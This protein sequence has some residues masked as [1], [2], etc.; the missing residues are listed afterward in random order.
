MRKR[1]KL[2]KLLLMSL[3]LLAS[4]MAS[5]VDI[6]VD[7]IKYTI[8]LT[9]K[10]ATVARQT[11]SLSKQN[12]VIPDFVTYNGENYPVTTIANRAFSVCSSLTGSLT[13]GNNVTSIGDLAFSKCSGFTGSLTIGNSVTS[14]GAYAFSNCSGFTG[15]LTIGNSVTSIGEYAFSSCSG[16][17]GSLTIPNSVTS[18]GDY[19]FHGCS[20]FTG[21]LTLPNSITSISN[22]TFGLCEGLSGTLTIPTS[23][24][25]IGERA[26][27]S[28]KE[29]SGSLTIPNSVT[30]IG[31]YAF[32]SCSGFTG[33][34][35]IGDSVTSIG[36]YAFAF[37][38]GFAG[39]LTIGNAVAFIGDNAFYYC[40]GFSTLKIGTGV[41][42]IVHFA[43]YF[44]KF[45]EIT[46]E[47][48]IPPTIIF[49][50]DNKY[51]KAFT[52]SN[53]SKPLYV[54][55]E[56]LQDYKTAYEWKDFEYIYPIGW[57]EPTGITLDKEAVS[58]EVKG[59][60]TLAATVA[61][62]DASDKSVTWT[63]SSTSIAT[64]MDGVV[65][66]VKAGTATI[67]ATTVNGLKA[68]CKVTVVVPPSSV[69]IYPTSK[70]LKPSE[71]VTLSATVSPSSAYDKSV[72]WTSSN[73]AVAE[74]DEEGVVTAIS[75]GTATITA[76]TIN[77][78]TATCKVTVSDPD[79][80][81]YT[82]DDTNM[83]ATVTGLANSSATLN[84]PVIPD[85]KVYNGKTYT[86]TAIKDS[87]FANSKKLTGS[88]TIGN[89]VITIGKTAFASC[90]ALTG[91]LTIGNSVSIISNSAFHGCKGFT[92]SLTIP[93]SVTYIGNEA[94]YNCSG[95]TGDLTIGNA[96]ESIGY[97]AF[98]N[99]T[100]FSGSLTIPNSVTTLGYSAFQD[101]TGFTGSLTIGNALTAIEKETFKG[102]DGF[103]GT[104]TIGNS[105]ATIGESAFDGCTQFTGSLTIPNSTIEIGQYAFRNCSA[106]DGTL[107]LGENLL[108][109]GNYAFDHCSGLN[110]RLTIPNSVTTIGERAFWV[111]SGFTGPLSLSTSLSAINMETFASCESIESVIIPA[112]VKTIDGGAFSD[113]KSL[114]SCTLEDSAEAISIPGRVTGYNDF[115]GHYFPIYG[116]NHQFDNCPLTYLYIGRNIT[117][118]TS[119]IF[120]GN[121]LKEL[122]F[123][124]EVTKIKPAFNSHTSIVKVYS[125]NTTPPQVETSNFCSTTTYETA[126]LLVPNE[127]REKYKQAEYWK[128]FFKISA[129]D[130]ID[131]TGITLDRETARIKVGD[132]LTLTATVLPDDTT[133]KSVTWTSGDDAVATVIDGVVTANGWGT[134][135]I[136]ATTANGLSASCEVTV[137]MMGDVNN[138]GVINVA[139]VSLTSSYIAGLEP[140]GFS[141]VAADI[142]G[143]GEIT[144]TD[145]VLIARMILDTD[146][147]AAPA[148]SKARST[149]S[150]GALTVTRHAKEISLSLPESGYTALQADINLPEGVTVTSASLCGGYAGSHLLMTADKGS[151]TLRLVL[152]S[153]INAALRE[154]DEFVRISL[155]DV[156]AG[157]IE[158]C[159]IVASDANG[160]TAAF[161]LRD[162]G[163]MSGVDTAGVG[164]GISVEA[165]AEG[166]TVNG[167]AGHTV[168]CYSI[169]GRTVKGAVAESDSETIALP[170]GIYVILVADKTYKISVK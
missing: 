87:A 33:S 64:V 84:D 28:C 63:S 39:S 88:L 1:N 80:F 141:V 6:T 48:A 124:P 111:C 68:S 40:S 56:S 97:W 153:P 60:T 116:N 168:R 133:D 37:C 30:S 143:D 21:S 10:E 138:D 74:V 90:T 155:S 102:C 150:R 43:F 166:V 12:L 32:F 149:V 41:K 170:A 27:Q 7:D 147:K 11:S 128:R 108:T 106:L 86:V 72:S 119:E 2:Y 130:G 75:P 92:G 165:S 3:L 82:Y 15:S 145:A 118:Q 65:T 95:F 36:K 98:R 109:I 4:Q 51:T 101:C 5:A 137:W 55:A 107:T 13:I 77:G 135:T 136:T 35:T 115:S 83:T 151:G 47:A 152:F 158:G 22:G 73:D 126:T 16:F 113:C 71:T 31:E 94:F 132:E 125:Y 29:F 91:T 19:A 99:C 134:T 154:G 161:T 140:A 142:N 139:D 59:N 120:K 160:N 67:T 8:D 20:E 24:T 50:E 131:A 66:G 58:V 123:G 157:E 103:S 169:D 45:N 100:G 127:S 70:T 23:V 163:W 129:L 105:V 159:N 18:I 148:A 81:T 89:S 54:P 42:E 76:T 114:K 78:K 52:S 144:V 17:T 104:L 122:Y 85:T 44:T 61:P 93:N 164:A 46:S 9:T 156:P 112:S 117:S 69:S 38:S 162:N 79:P 14:I 26:F 110:G 167:A 146:T 121:T 25:S 53:Y 57:V 49:D 62:E 34:L 96:V